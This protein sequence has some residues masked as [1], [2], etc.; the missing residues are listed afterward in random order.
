MVSAG[1]P[2]AQMDAVDLDTDLAEAETQVG[3]FDKLLLSLRNLLKSAQSQVKAS[4]AKMEHAEEE[5]SRIKKLFA[6]KA[7]SKFEESDA[8]LLE[9]ESPID[10][11][12]D[13]LTVQSIDAIREAI[14]IG[15]LDADEKMKRRK[16]NRNRATLY[17]PVEGVVLRRHESSER[18][19]PAGEVL[20]EIG[21]LEDLEVIAEILTQ[22]VVNITLGDPA[23]VEGPAIGPHPIPGQV[24]RIFPQGF[25]KVSSLGVEQQRVL[26]IIKFDPESFAKRRKA[27]R[28]LGADYRMRVKIYTDQKADAL[29]IPRSALFRSTSGTWQAF[30]VRNG[31]ARKVGL[32]IG[33]TNDFKVEVLSGMAAGEQVILAPD[34]SLNDGQSVEA[35][36]IR[37]QPRQRIANFTK[38]L[39][40]R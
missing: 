4:G 10:L 13:S 30:V 32:E 5:F 20:L 29:K 36:V 28:A 35:N 39:P 16:R 27:G 26:V 8:R 15:R 6:G 23:D 1:K 12:K 9:I 3:Q 7:A 18:V 40:D 21:R 38:D 24:A 14:F 33:L 22:D 19:R 25:K 11:E 37:Q 2:V 17:S 34:S 31:R